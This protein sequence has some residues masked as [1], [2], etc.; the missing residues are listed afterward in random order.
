M[1]L[2]K[3]KKKLSRKSDGRA[4]D[5]RSMLQD[6]GGDPSGLSVK[7]LE[8]EIGKAMWAN[9]NPDEEFPRTN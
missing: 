7:Q 3:F 1:N 8:S 5:L 9:E 4:E 6:L 2:S